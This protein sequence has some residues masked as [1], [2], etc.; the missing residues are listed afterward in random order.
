LSIDKNDRHRGSDEGD[1]P[2]LGDGEVAPGD[3]EV[4]I[5]GEEGDQAKS[6]AT[7]GLGEAEAVETEAR[8]RGRCCW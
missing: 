5:G 2:L 1:A 6:K 4:V 3:G 8:P 7:D